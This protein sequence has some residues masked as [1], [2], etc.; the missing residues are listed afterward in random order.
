MFQGRLSITSC[1]TPEKSVQFLS[2]REVAMSILHENDI[3]FAS[4]LHNNVYLDFSH[5]QL[6]FEWRWI[7]TEDQTVII[8]NN[9]LEKSWSTVKL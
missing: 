4:V 9:V 8:I 7:F 5:K 2:V 3:Q 1:V 6:T